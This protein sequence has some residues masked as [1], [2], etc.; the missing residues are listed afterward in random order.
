VSIFIAES[1]VR[2][3]F[4]A[5]MGLLL[6]AHEVIGVEDLPIVIWLC[7]AS[8]GRIS[9]LSWQD[10][11]LDGIASRLCIVLQSFSNKAVV[12]HA[13]LHR[14]PA[15]PVHV[16]VACSASLGLLVL[17]DIASVALMFVMPK[18]MRALSRTLGA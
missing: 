11:C 12:A 16:P 14:F 3:D 10:C 7:M 17:L 4:W 15:G 1:A 6:P 9:S 5:R 8:G 13:S 2:S 18:L